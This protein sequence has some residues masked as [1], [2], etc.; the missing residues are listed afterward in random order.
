VSDETGMGAIFENRRNGWRKGESNS[1]VLMA[2]F[3]VEG[4]PFADVENQISASA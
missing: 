3:S 4:E 1:L 2:Y